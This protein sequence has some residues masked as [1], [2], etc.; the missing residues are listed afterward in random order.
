MWYLV[1]ALK[2]ELDDAIID[3]KRSLNLACLGTICD[4]VPLVGL[5]RVIAKRGLELLSDTKR[6]GL[7][8]LRNVVDIKGNIG[9][10]DVS[11]LIGPRLDAVD[12]IVH[13]E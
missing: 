8:A 5:N 2:K 3:A 1:L 12:R 9:C 10:G 11:F 13:G 4:M 7:R 6:P